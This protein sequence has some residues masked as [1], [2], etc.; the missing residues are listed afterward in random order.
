MIYRKIA[1][2]FWNDAKVRQLSDDAKFVLLFLLTHPGLTALGAM[3][4]TL[5]GLAA[6]LGWRL[7]RFTRAIEESVHLGM[8]VLNESAAFVGLPNFIKY[9]EPNGP[10]AVTKAWPRAVELIPECPERRALLARCRAY[11]DAKSEDFR[12]A[13]NDGVWDALGHGQGMALTIQEPEQEPEQEPKQE[14]DS[15][16]PPAPQ[17]GRT[18]RTSARRGSK[19]DPNPT[20]LPPRPVARTRGRAREASS[21]TRDAGAALALLNELIGS[22]FKTTTSGNVKHAMARLGEEY[23]LADLQTVVRAKAAEWRGT[24]WAKFLRPQTLFGEKFGAYL[25]AA[26]RGNGHHPRRVNAA[27]DGVTSGEVKL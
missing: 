21:R 10:N 7:R 24:E 11:L 20:P 14:Q 27:W 9:N 1:P 23:T 5:A 6:E 26:K 12:D 13:I 18:P 4:A 22:N 16:A 8:V 19:P 15:S 2:H 25:E 17:G 3:R